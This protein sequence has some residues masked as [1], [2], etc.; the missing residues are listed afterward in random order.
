MLRRDPDKLQAPEALVDI[1]VSNAFRY[2]LSFY[3]PGA[4]STTKE[5]GFYPPTGAPFKTVT[6]ENPDPTTT[7]K[8]QIT[9]FTDGNVV[10]N[11]YEWIPTT[12]SWAL[13]TGNGLRRETRTYFWQGSLRIETNEVAD[14]QGQ[15]VFRQVETYQA[16]D[17]VGVT[18]LIARICGS[19]W[20]T[21]ND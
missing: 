19:D 20:R 16:F 13:V 5:G 11:S 7:N 12:Q 3:S 18:N 15:V 10:T 6:V 14:A 2:A 21:P 17:L 4:F 8:L 9:E 1:T